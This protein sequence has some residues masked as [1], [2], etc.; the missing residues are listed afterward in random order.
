MKHPNLPL[1]LA[2]AAL[3]A[4]CANPGGITPR[5]KAITPTAAGMPA[6]TTPAA[7]LA[8]D[9]WRALGDPALSALI[10]RALAEQPNLKV[11]EARLRRAQALQA[12]A[13]AAGGPQLGLAADATR[14]LYTQNGQVPPP[15]G[16]TWRTPG[17]LQ[18]EGGWEIDFFGRNR[19]ALAAA[20]GT[21]RAAQAEV[22]A[23]RV[24][25]AS[26]VARTWA[27][28]GRLAQQKAIAERALQQRTELLAL[29]QQRVQAG[30]E[31]VLELRQAEGA[32]PDARQQIEQIDEQITLT[33][34]AL[35]ALSAQAPDALNALPLPQPSLALTLPDTL[36]ADLLA[37]RA[38]I[39]AARWRIEAATQDVAAA[40][41]AFY[42]NVNLRA[43]VGLSSLGL[44]RLLK[45]GSEQ[46][47]VGAALHLPIFDAGRLRANLGGR[48]A[49]LDAAVESYNAAVLD[50][51]REVADQLASLASLARQQQQQAQAQAAAE[52]AFDIATQRYRA[53]LAT[54]LAVLNAESAVLAQRRLGAELR[55]RVLD[56]QLALTRSLG[57]GFTAD[58]ELTRNPA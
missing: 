8:A 15:L 11:A 43:F 58:A 12:A 53:G 52:A 32:L 9:W 3:L 34:H 27:Q 56:T 18:L 46:A 20:T 2:T 44:D 47:G 51:V 39:T 13:D 55:A 50:A 28:L 30:L 6:S 10:D 7:P 29:T 5:A 45:S 26:Q 1:A 25:L 17:T 40:R 4:G 35:A 33:R 38:D 21:V 23:A 16:G 24:M 37:R 31:T 42:P 57:G 48:T 19:A 54:Q 36:P 14:Q 22:A 41:A 49:E